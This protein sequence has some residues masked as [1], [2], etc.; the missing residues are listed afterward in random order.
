MYDKAK[1]AEQLKSIMEK[2]GILQR[3]LS[4][5]LETTEAT[6]SRY[7]KGFR[8]PNIETAV[9]IARVLNVSM[10]ELVGVDPPGKPRTPPDVS[11]LISCYN[12]A[13]TQQREALWAIISTYGIMTPEQQAVVSATIETE[14]SESVQS[15]E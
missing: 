9:E 11:I 14:K 5:K 10:D 7:C 3:T 1:F 13:T 2:R 6:V 8:T 12:K 4:E 15:A